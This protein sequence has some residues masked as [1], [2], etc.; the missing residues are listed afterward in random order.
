MRRKLLGIALAALSG[1]TTL[2]AQTSGAGLVEQAQKLESNGKR[3]EALALFRQVIE[4]TPAD[5]QAHLGIGRI[6][7]AQGKYIEARRHLQSAIEFATERELNEALSTMAVSYAFEGN[8]GTAAKYYQKVIERLTQFGAPLDVATTANALGRVYLE[9]GDFANAEKWYRAGYDSTKKADKPA[10][11]QVDLAEMRWEHAQ[12]RIAARRRQFD[13]ARKHLAQARAVVER[14]TIA[15]AQSTNI[16]YLAGYIA[17][18][19]GRVDEAIAEL[20]KADQRDPFILSL[21]AQ[22]HEQKQDHQKA[23]ELYARI[24]ELPGHTLQVAFARPLAERRL[25][26]R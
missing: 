11:E 9:T 8:A 18:Y 25:A 26:G 15:A 1:V 23:R 7:D 10:P 3:S 6:L 21:L 2:Y 14:G 13:Q 12:G 16:P 17:F 19:E 24:L 4:K 20:S 22:A 5:F